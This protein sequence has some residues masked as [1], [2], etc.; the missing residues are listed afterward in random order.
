MECSPFLVTATRTHLHIFFSFS[1]SF[2]PLFFILLKWFHQVILY[3]RLLARR[4][5]RVDLCI[6]YT[7]IVETNCVDEKAIGIINNGVQFGIF[8]KAW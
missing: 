1:F 8:L 6:S 2:F 4:S 3:Y 7:N 5:G